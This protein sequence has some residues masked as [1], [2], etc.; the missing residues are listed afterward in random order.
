MVW[1]PVLGIFNTQTD[2]EACSCTQGGCR[3]NALKVD[4]WEKSSSPHRR[5]EP[6]SASH[7]A[8]QSNAL[9]TQ[10]SLP[11][12]VHVF[13]FFP[14]LFFFLFCQSKRFSLKKTHIVAFAQ[15]V[16]HRDAAYAHAARHL[17]WWWCRTLFLTA[18]QGGGPSL[19]MPGLLRW[20][21]RGADQ[22]APADLQSQRGGWH[23]EG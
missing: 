9:L 12:F 2:V 11:L 7:L 18:S 14:C 20:G 8:F 3:D 22:L 1:L 13:F 5:L 6:T 15:D 19:Q 21:G 16:W 4:W 17:Q 10:L 23:T